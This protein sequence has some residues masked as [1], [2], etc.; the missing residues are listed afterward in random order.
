MSD[1]IQLLP[2]SVANQIAAGEVIQRPSSVV[3][4][5]VENSVDAGAKK[6]RV[7][8]KDAGRSLIQVIDDGKGMS[9]TDARLSFERHATSKIKKAEDLFAIKT[10]GFRGE[11]LAS[12]AAV[13]QVEMKTRQDRDEL[14]T[15]IV[16]NASEVEKQEFSNCE[17]GCNISVKNL[18][19]NIPA[20]RRFL[21]S[22]NVEFSHIITQF[23]RIVLCFPEVHFSLSHNGSEVYNLPPSNIHKRILYLF[24]NS[25]DQNMVPVNTETTLVKIS[26]FVGKPQFA[27]KRLHQQFLFVNQRF[28]KHPY[29]HKAL[30]MAYENILPADAQ[31]A[32]F[33]YFDIEPDKIDINVHPTKTEIKFEDSPAIFQMIRVSVKEALG[34]H[35]ITPSIDF[36]MEGSF[37][38]PVLNKKTE[39]HSPQIGINPNYNPFENENGENGQNFNVFGNYRDK[40]NLKNWEKLFNP[41]KEDTENEGF[42]NTSQM[43]FLQTT[44]TH[45]V[46]SNVFMLKNKFVVT[47]VKSGLMMINKRR[48]HERILYEQFMESLSRSE[49]VSQISLFPT[50]FNL[51]PADAEIL[52]EIQ[53]D[54]FKIGFDI[55][56]FGNNT[57]VINA[58]PAVF[59]NYSPTLLI[60]HF[61]EIF[62][63]TE[64]DIKK[65][66]K[67]KIA[68]SLAQAAAIDFESNMSVIE[69]KSLIDNL[70]ACQ[71]PNY[72][73]SGKTII[74]ILS[75]EEIERKF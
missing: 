15:Y 32:Y 9:A 68:K 17:I 4:E 75:M 16:I 21:K 24:G 38:I 6:I 37:Q 34:K 3:K 44:T 47:P 43:E 62:K 1:I 23:Q 29:F 42:E 39:F 41:E 25:F 70:F 59:E 12:V 61:L 64:G 58:T 27:R 20:R 54:L 8:I 60:E 28:M 18:F 69:M 73:P 66:A 48:A 53:D 36:D 72:T 50:T 26:G 71:V 67:E 7:I 31:P 30:L 51:Q 49:S 11:A 2:D 35:N 14:G 13:A 5:L 10:M 40:D 55:R 33:I 22:D 19:F 74:H 46:S 56:E 45:A 65:E 63:G 52:V 57:F